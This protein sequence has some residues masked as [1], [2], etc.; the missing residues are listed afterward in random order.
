[1][2]SPIVTTTYTVIG[3]DDKNCFADTAYIP[4]RVF[5]IPT[6]EAGPDKTINVGKQLDLT[7]VISPD[8]TNVVWSPTG[9]IFRSDYP[10][11]TVKPNQTTVYTV[12]VVNGGG[13]RSRD[14]VTVYVICNGAN[15]FIPN[16][17]S[18]NNDQAN[19]V[20]YPRGTGLFRIKSARVFN[21]WGEVVYEKADF[22]ANDPSVGWDG[23]YKGKKLNIDV[24]VYI[25]EIMCDNNTILTYKG[26]IALIK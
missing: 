13:C 6:V 20:F 15:V 23:T 19:D 14:N 11:I 9:S 4:I 16:T 17:F 1:M 22:M 2:A 3:R 12:D 18:P 25:I 8:V 26:N 5:G 24:Y 21:R 10:S 7:P